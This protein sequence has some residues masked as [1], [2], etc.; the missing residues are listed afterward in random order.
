MSDQLRPTEN[1]QERTKQTI[2][3]ALPW[4]ESYQCDNCGAYCDQTYTYAVDTAAFDNGATP[5]WDCPECDKQ[6]YRSE[7]SALS[8]DPFDL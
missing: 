4:L 7:E 6:Y 3:N 2:V 1:L 8:F 5:A